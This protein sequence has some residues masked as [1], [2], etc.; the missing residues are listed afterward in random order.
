M[1]K[2][3]QAKV[4]IDYEGNEPLLY[5]AANYQVITA[6]TNQTFCVHKIIKG[7]KTSYVLKL[8]DGDYYTLLDQRSK[9]VM[10]GLDVVKNTNTVV[11]NKKSDKKL[12]PKTDNNDSQLLE[13]ESKVAFDKDAETERDSEFQT[14]I[15]DITKVTLSQNNKKNDVSRDNLEQKQK[16]KNA[17]DDEKIISSFTKK[18]VTCR[19]ISGSIYL[20]ANCVL[21]FFLH[22]PI[23][24]MFGTWDFDMDSLV[25]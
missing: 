22:E 18:M 12:D 25:E 19:F 8:D 20:I 4:T 3:Y 13:K 10:A 23:S 6:Y 24:R 1:V 14:T 11:K 17:K 5:D 15:I 2:Y 7:K 16:D 9:E 21:L